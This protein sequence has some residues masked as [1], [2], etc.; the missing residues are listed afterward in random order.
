VL[1]NSHNLAC[2]PVRCVVQLGRRGE[3]KARVVSIVLDSPEKDFALLAVKLPRGMKN[4]PPA[5][6]SRARGRSREVYAIGGFRSNGV[7]DRLIRRGRLRARGKLQVVD[8]GDERP[9]IESLRYSYRSGS[10]FSGAG[11]FSARTGDLE[12]LHWGNSQYL[13]SP[14]LQRAHAVRIEGILADAR[15]QLGSIRSPKAR[16]AVEQ[17]TRPEQNTSTAQGGVQ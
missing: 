9:P 15:K 11:V 8:P 3:H 2:N 13:G 4:V 16:A 7:V 6:V 12:A 5:T 14:V 10:G 1:T 17:L